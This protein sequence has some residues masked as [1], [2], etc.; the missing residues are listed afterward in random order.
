MSSPARIVLVGCGEIAQLAHLPGLAQLRE[1]GLLEIAGVCDVD[2]GR[3]RAAATK[4]GIPAWGSDWRAIVVESAAAALSLC[5]PPGPNAEVAAQ[6]VEAGFHVICEKPPGRNVAQAKEMARAA[7][8]RPDRVTMIAFNRRH[9]PLYRRMIGLS[10]GLGN[11]QAFFARFSRAAMGGEPSNTVADWLTSDG[12]HALDLAVATMGWPESASVARQRTGSKEENVWTIQLFGANGSALLLLAF[13]AGRRLERFEWTGPGYDVIL[14]LPEWGEWAARGSPVRRWSSAEITGSPDFA[15]NYGFVEEYRAFAHA[16]AGSGP[17]PDND[18]LYGLAFMEL[19]RSL[20]EAS[21]EELVR[22]A[23]RASLSVPPEVDTPTFA[24]NGTDRSRRPVVSILQS[25]QAQ[26][27]YFT[28]EELSALGGVA[29]ISA[30]GGSPQ[31]L[32]EADVAVLGWGAPPLSA[33]ELERASRLKLVVILGASVGWAVDAR[34]LISRRIALC[35]TSGAIAKSVAEHCLALA[36]AG[37][38][39]LTDLDSQMHRGLW[40]PSRSGRFSARSLVRKAQK[41]PFLQPFKP[42][43]RPLRDQLVPRLN[44]QKGPLFSD[45]RGETVG[46]VGWGAIAREFAHLLGGFGCEIIAHSDHASVHELA[47]SGV[48]QAALGEVLGS[49]RIVSLHK[50]LSDRTRGFLDR[51]KLALMR[52][53]SVLV[54]TA[55]ADLI[56]EPDLIEFARRGDVVVALDVYH[57]EPLSS[58]HPLR[59]LTNVILT[60]HSASTTPQCERRVGSEALGIVTDW[61]S[62]RPVP[63][64]DLDRL[65]SMT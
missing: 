31:A 28:V 37:L 30:D 26:R 19:V 41:L 62:G 60:P 4:Y 56:S 25:P 16:V 18:F 55:R 61:I 33:E 40:P 44:G 9:A 34:Q 6:A 13:A 32:A 53:G 45:L 7:G 12:S 58:R 36:L 5:L 20:R 54:N 2:A 23:P 1:E 38:R 64:L 39:R 21:S 48:R 14:E 11:P 43:L 22:I 65:A 35:N 46:L 8:E 50:G 10:A 3:A 57:T 17:R 24:M 47:A 29:D 42:I 49:S 52:R 63:G 59:S 51:D 15:V 27:R